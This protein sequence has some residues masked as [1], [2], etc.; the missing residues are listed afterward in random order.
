MSA[1][2]PNLDGARAADPGMTDLRHTWEPYRYTCPACSEVV[3][4]RDPND[5]CPAKV[6]MRLATL[7]AKVDALTAQ[8]ATA[9]A[10]GRRKGLEEAARALDAQH[11]AAQILDARN[12]GLNEP[13]TCRE[14][15]RRIRALAAKAS[16]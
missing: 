1:D 14:M 2:T 4:R 11:T 15:A 3:L 9:E 10:A 16:A 12:L 5:L 8:V 7:D 6:A 13:D